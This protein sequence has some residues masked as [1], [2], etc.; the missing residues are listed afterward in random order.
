MSDQKW[1]YFVT[2]TLDYK[3]LQRS[4]DNTS[5]DG[6]ELVSFLSHR[7]HLVAVFKREPRPD[8]VEV[9]PGTMQP[10]VRP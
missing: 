9:I 5:K 6:Y 1:E 8:P 4:C 2:E 10:V 3:G 7:D